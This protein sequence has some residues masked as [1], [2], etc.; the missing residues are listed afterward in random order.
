MTSYKTN[1]DVSELL[2]TDDY[3]D[4]VNRFME[5]YMLLQVQSEKLAMIFKNKC[6]GK[7]VATVDDV[8]FK[9]GNFQISHK[10]LSSQILKDDRRLMIGY[11][12]YLKKR[13]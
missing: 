12:K 13:K 10:L 2:K 5:G 8:E 1:K 6:Y 4:L 9:K 7:H 11:L 3:F